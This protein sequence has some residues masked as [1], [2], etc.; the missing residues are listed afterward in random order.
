MHCSSCSLPQ[1]I[2]LGT[3]AHRQSC[4]NQSQDTLNFDS[5]S[6]I[7]SL[8][9]E[10]ET[11]T[12]LGATFCLRVRL[13]LSHYVLGRSCQLNIQLNTSAALLVATSE[14]GSWSGIPENSSNLA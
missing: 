12:N 14:V 5:I 11:V 8:E 13:P 3:A 4:E 2:H 1:Q 10:F 6:T 9:A 7:A